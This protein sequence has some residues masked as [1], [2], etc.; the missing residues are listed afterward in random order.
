MQAGIVV[1][2]RRR[3]QRVA[4]LLGLYTH[5]CAINYVAYHV[6]RPG[7]PSKSRLHLRRTFAKVESGSK[8]V[9][10]PAAMLDVA[11]RTR[12]VSLDTTAR[13]L[14]SQAEAIVVL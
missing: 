4:P 11:S 2:T 9:V 14:A 12:H 10:I 13:V 7:T 3:P 8:R 6:V 1:L 5:A